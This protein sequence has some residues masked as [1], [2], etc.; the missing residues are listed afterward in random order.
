MNIIQ[1]LTEFIE[2]NPSTVLSR[3]HMQPDIIDP[4]SLIGKEILHKFRLES[5]EER[6]FNGVVLSYN[7]AAKTH[8]VVYDGETEHQH[9]DLTEDILDGDLKVV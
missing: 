6:C 2:A 9:F 3:L 8:E 4:F 5:G 1:E 7:A